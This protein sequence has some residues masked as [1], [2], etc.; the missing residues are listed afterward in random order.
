M[1]RR[2][3]DTQQQAAQGSEASAVTAPLYSPERPAR[4]AEKRSFLKMKQNSRSGAPTSARI[5]EAA[6]RRGA[7]QKAEEAPERPARDRSELTHAPIPRPG[8]EPPERSKWTKPCGTRVGTAPVRPQHSKPS[9]HRGGDSVQGLNEPLTEGYSGP[10]VK[11]TEKRALEGTNCSRNLTASQGKNSQ[12][13]KGIP[14]KKKKK[15][16]ALSVKSTMS[17]TQS[18]LLK[19]KPQD[20]PGV[21]WLGIHLPRQGTCVRSL[22]REL[23]SHMP[24]ATESIHFNK[25]PAQPTTASK[26]KP[27]KKETRKYIQYLV[28]PYYRKEF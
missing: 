26:P 1:E 23:R 4:K 9:P 3:S 15:N 21:L 22:V 20:F 7:R 13:F 5:C 19:T 25:G 12:I 27:T 8:K 2:S 28:I 24:G 11:D 14:K 6:H 17:R 16:L 10:A 18:T